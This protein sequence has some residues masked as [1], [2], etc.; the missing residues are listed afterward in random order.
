MPVFGG[1]SFFI[2]MLKILR[3]G[4][5]NKSGFRVLLSHVIQRCKF[6]KKQNV[7]QMFNR[8]VSVK[9]DVNAD[10]LSGKC[11]AF[12]VICYLFFNYV[13][14]RINNTEKLIKFHFFQTKEKLK[15]RQDRERVRLSLPKVTDK[16]YYV[17]ELTNK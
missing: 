14:E 10:G 6:R 12:F 17:V 9:T 5:L 4:L 16:K 2:C 3:G 11:I 7:R 1:M 13:T 8:T 15:F